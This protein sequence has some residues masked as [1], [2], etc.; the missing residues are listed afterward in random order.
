MMQVLNLVKGESN[1]N[2]IKFNA[3]QSEL[4]SSI[5]HMGEFKDFEEAN[6]EAFK[7]LKRTATADKYIFIANINDGDS[8]H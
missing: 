6:L 3:I 1:A 2:T 7:C 8:H 5:Y 4:I